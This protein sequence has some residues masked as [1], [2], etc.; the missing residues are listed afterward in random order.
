MSGRAR[1][2]AVTSTFIRL[3]SVSRTGRSPRSGTGSLA[4]ALAGLIG[5]SLAVL[6]WLLAQ[7]V[8]FGVA[9]HT[10]LTEHGVTSHRHAYAVPLAAGAAMTAL[11]AV[12]L[13]FVLHLTF[14]RT[15]GNTTRPAAALAADRSSRRLPFARAVRVAPVLAA[16]LFVVVEAVEVT[17]SGPP[18]DAMGAVVAGGAALQFLC[19]WA[20]AAT[21]RMLVHGVEDLSALPRMGGTSA[22]P[23]VARVPVAEARPAS[24]ARV[25][26]WHGRAPPTGRHVHAIPT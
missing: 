7:A 11:L 6:G 23:A 10:H 19:V 4:G 16:G 3:G 26:R 5:V 1:V 20:A 18:A 13:L 21:A 22:W 14:S 12:L 24:E 2:S 15:D 8:T 9:E 17:G 25:G